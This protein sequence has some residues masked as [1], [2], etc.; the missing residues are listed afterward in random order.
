MN[1]IRKMVFFANWKI[2]MRTRKEVEDYVQVIKDNLKIPN[3][4]LVEIQIMTDF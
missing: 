3:T 4:G 1:H 2:Y